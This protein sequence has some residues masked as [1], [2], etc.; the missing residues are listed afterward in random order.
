MALSTHCAHR[1]IPTLLQYGAQVPRC[2]IGAMNGRSI[3]QMVTRDAVAF[4][5]LVNHCRGMMNDDDFCEL[6]LHTNIYSHD[7][8]ALHCTES[9]DIAKLLVEQPRHQDN[10]QLLPACQAQLV[11]K[12]G[13]GLTP[14]EAILAEQVE[15]TGRED[16]LAYLESFESLAV[17]S[18]AA[19][20]VSKNK[21]SNGCIAVQPNPALND[22]Q[23]SVAQEAFHLI[24]ETS[25]YPD[26]IAHD[27]LGFL[28]PLDV[29][30]RA[31]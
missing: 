21:L 28:S 6:L 18:P 30:K 8:L 29:M 9:V 4:R 11:S 3:L 24:M 25:E 10:K 31:S 12:N 16:L 1:S 2:E 14:R 17:S 7:N 26:S 19:V 13:R 27:I 20:C 23:R 22:F 15:S 5:A